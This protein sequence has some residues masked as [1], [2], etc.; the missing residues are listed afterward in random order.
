MALEFLFLFE[1]RAAPC[2]H[3][4]LAVPSLWPP[5]ALNPGCRASGGGR[6]LTWAA[7]GDEAST[8]ARSRTRLVDRC[9]QH[10]FCS[11]E[12]VGRFAAGLLLGLYGLHMTRAD[13]EPIHRRVL[14]PVP[15]WPGSPWG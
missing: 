1:T 13:S 14:G 9:R 15:S 11:E 7:C 5:E 10:L 3:W 4:G 2:L 12:T 8:V 6:L